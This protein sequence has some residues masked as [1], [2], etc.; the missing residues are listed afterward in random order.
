MHEEGA[1]RPVL[2]L[3]CESQTTLKEKEGS[4]PK[5]K[6]EFESQTTNKISSYVKKGQKMVIY[7]RLYFC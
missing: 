5:M 2:K 7:E 4:H 3:E 6:L 1:S